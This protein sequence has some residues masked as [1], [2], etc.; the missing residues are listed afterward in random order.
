MNRIKST[1]YFIYFILL[2]NFPLP[3]L[4]SY[5]LNGP[6]GKRKAEITRATAQTS[7]ISQ[8]HAYPGHRSRHGTII[9]F[10]TNTE[11]LRINHVLS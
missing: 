1:Y 3:M 10:F 2:D 4:E 11:S 6:N 5:A 8:R 7:Y 9:F